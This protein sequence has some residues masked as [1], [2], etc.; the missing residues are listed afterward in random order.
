M[1]TLIS[2][3]MYAAKTTC[4]IQRLENA[5][6]A[7]KKICVLKY[8]RD[9]RV[10]G[11]ENYITTHEMSIMKQRMKVKAHP[12]GHLEGDFTPKLQKII[13]EADVIGIDEGQ[14]LDGLKD[15]CYNQ[16]LKGKSVIVSALNGTFE[17]KP[18]PN[19]RD[20]EPHVDE[21]IHL[22]AVCNKCKSYNAIYTER[23]SRQKDLIVIGGKEMYRAVCRDCLEEG[24]IKSFQPVFKMDE[25]PSAVASSISSENDEISSGSSTSVSP[26]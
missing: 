1:I 23:K 11:S 22:K 7:N 19:V 5:S 25:N 8:Y 17:Q 18:F 2:G 15:F 9:V 13:D 4:L 24:K 3:P 16:A 21:H 10:P 26:F 14:F 12:V 6:N 20:L